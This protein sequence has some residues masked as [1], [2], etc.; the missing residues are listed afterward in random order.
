[1]VDQQA[2]FY[3]PVEKFELSKRYKMVIYYRTLDL[4][5]CK[6]FVLRVRIFQFQS[7]LL[8]T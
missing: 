6:E 7:E 5:F 4:L 1:M 2:E 3:I 8:L